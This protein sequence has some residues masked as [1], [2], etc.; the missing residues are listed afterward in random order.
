MPDIPKP[1]P[2]QQAASDAYDA[3]QLRL[4]EL[5]RIEKL[6]RCGIPKRYLSAKTEKTLSGDV[7][8]GRGLYITGPVG[9][10][11]T[12]L[13]AAVTIELVDEGITAKFLPSV[14]ALGNIRATFNGRGSENQE[15]QK[16]TECGVLVL[17]DFGKEAIS[18]WVLQTLYQVI[19]ERYNQELPIIITTQFSSKDLAERLAS[20]GDIETAQAII[21]RLYEMCDAVQVGGEDRRL[22]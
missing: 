22:A 2:E 10:G 11:K 3:E 9:A 1:T 19:N 13:A 7:L 15:V 14:S 8:S 4:K 18:E 17:D 6:T 5:K 20:K 21:S 16:L 12:Y